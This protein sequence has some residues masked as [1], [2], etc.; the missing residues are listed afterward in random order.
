MPVPEVPGG[1]VD[2]IIAPDIVHDPPLELPVWAGQVDAR[3]LVVEP[4]LP[5]HADNGRR[6]LEVSL[7]YLT[8]ARHDV[9]VRCPAGVGARRLP[10]ELGRLRMPPLQVFGADHR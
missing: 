9:G 3:V 2:Q 7:R 4:R 5:E 8:L 10:R 6:P 1:T